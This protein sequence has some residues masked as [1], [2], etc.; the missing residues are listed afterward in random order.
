MTS[1]QADRLLQIKVG[2]NQRIMYHVVRIP[3]S[4]YFRLMTV[5]ECLDKLLK[6]VLVDE[7]LVNVDM[8]NPPVM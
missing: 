6:P 1:L 5:M 8:D 2:F 4:D 7:Q 3:R